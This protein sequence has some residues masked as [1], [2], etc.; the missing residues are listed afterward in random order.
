MG[1]CCEELLLQVGARKPSK[2]QSRRRKEQ[3]GAGRRRKEEGAGRK[4]EGR[5]SYLLFK[6]FDLLLKPWPG[7]REKDRYQLIACEL[8]IWLEQLCEIFL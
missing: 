3:E 4:E 2:N 6:N 7:R 1:S 5:G 8:T